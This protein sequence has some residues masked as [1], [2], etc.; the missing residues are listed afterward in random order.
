MAVAVFNPKT[1]A[2]GDMVL[3]CLLDFVDEEELLREL[4][5][6]VDP[7]ADVDVE[8]SEKK[9]ND[10]LLNNLDV[11]VNEDVELSFEEIKE[12]ILDSD[13]DEEVKNSSIE[14]FKSLNDAEKAIHGDDASFHEV[15]EADALVDIIGSV[16]A[17]EEIDL[18]K[19]FSTP[20]CV[21]GGFVETEHGFLPVPAPATEEIL[22]NSD[23]IWKGGPVDDELLTPTGAALLSYFVDESVRAFPEIVSN[24]VS[25]ASGDKSL[26]VA[27]YLTLTLGEKRGLLDSDKVYVL[28]T[29]VDD[30][31]GESVGYLKEKLLDNDALDV[32]VIPLHMKKDRS[33]F[34]VQVLS[35]EN[36][37]EVLSRI[38]VKE[39]GT[40][41]VRVFPGVHRYIAN[42][43]FVEVNYKGFSIRVKVGYLDNGEIIDLSAEY[44]DCRKVSISE[45]LSLKKVKRKAESLAEEIIGD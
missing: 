18:G 34:L 13:L 3:G 20:I 4:M 25:R 33:G 1:G 42:R 45:D 11:S 43:K 32:S 31:D 26:E 8:F 24:E 2:S 5:D 12:F 35:K 37:T 6:F 16:L 17:F 22:K 39:L 23:L 40:L 21:G 36:N 38:L 7:I 27:N 14:V 9:V 19:V 30:V 41:G 44:E 15:G 29:N 10:I 28:E